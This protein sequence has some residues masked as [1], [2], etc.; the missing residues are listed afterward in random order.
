MFSSVVVDV[1]IFLAKA[2]SEVLHSG[3]YVKPSDPYLP[4]HRC[5]P[6]ND[7]AHYTSILTSMLVTTEEQVTAGSD[8]TDFMWSV[9]G[10]EP[11]SEEYLSSGNG[12]DGSLFSV[13]G[14]VCGVGSCEVIGGV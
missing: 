14:G 2:N 6:C 10:G 13:N 9:E 11:S 5:N 3:C 1:I 12:L 7:H 4:S 8:P